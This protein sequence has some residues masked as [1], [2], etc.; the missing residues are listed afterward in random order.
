MNFH[1]YTEL[2]SIDA[3]RAKE[4]QLEDKLLKRQDIAL[5]KESYE[6]ARKDKQRKEEDA[7]S[8]CSQNDGTK[9]IKARQEATKADT[10]YQQKQQEYDGAMAEAKAT[11]I[12][13]TSPITDKQ[14]NWM[15]A[16]L[17]LTAGLLLSLL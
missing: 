16:V 14:L 8:S 9:C 10:R 5:K 3:A 12:K 11:A 15:N 4:T 13:E 17:P 1:Q 2:K 7:R 6:E